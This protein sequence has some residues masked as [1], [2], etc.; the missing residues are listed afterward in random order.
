M[1]AY[2][3]LRVERRGA[4][5]LCGFDNPPHGY[6]DHGTVQELDAFTAACAADAELRAI[7]FFGVVPGVFIQHYSV[8][9]LAALSRQLREQRVSV[10][11]AK[12]VPER[13][14]DGV[15]ARLGTMNAVTIAAINGNAM[16]GGFEFCLS[17]DIRVGEEGLYSLGLPE[18]NIGILPGAGGTQKLPRLVGAGRALE[19]VVLGR[20]IT[21][22]EA[23]RLGIVTE[24]AP[25]GGALDLALALAERIAQQPARAVAHVKH[26]V[27]AAVDTP[28]SDGM[29]RER[30]LFLDLLISDEAMARMSTMN[31]GER[32]IR[33]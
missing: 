4:V 14:L 29:G 8:H 23:A 21:P 13:Q 10:D 30:T 19:L 32:D 18:V 12:V 20:N 27:R 3:Q 5:A 6:M 24:L 9:E 11:P 1:T 33:A 16:G 31:A 15:F 2:R 25:A 22:A 28:L 26:L 7:V 17:C